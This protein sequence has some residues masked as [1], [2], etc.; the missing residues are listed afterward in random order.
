MHLPAAQFGATFPSL[1]LRNLLRGWRLGL[2]S[3][4]AIARAMGITPLDP[5]KILVGPDNKP[6]AT[7]AG[8]RFT[9]DTPLWLYVLAEAQQ[10]MQTKPS[11]VI[12]PNLGSGTLGPVGSRIVAETIIGL[13]S[14]DR[15]SFLRIEPNG[16]PDYGRTTTKG[17][18]FEMRDLITKAHEA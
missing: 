13:I 16:T 17:R 5:Q 8:G 3:G 15:F 9:G 10:N 12:R 6:I 4:E 2:P 18:V 1:A 14:E 11:G 7:L